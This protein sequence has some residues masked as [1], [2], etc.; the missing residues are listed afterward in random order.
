MAMKRKRGATTGSNYFVH[1]NKRRRRFGARRRRNGR[2]GSQFTSAQAGNSTSI[3]F[4]SRKLRP[5]AY[6]NALWKDTLFKTHY[7]SCIDRLSS[8]QMPADSRDSRIGYGPVHGD[9]AFWTAGGGA[10]AVDSTTPLPLFQDDITIRG[11]YGSLT[12]T[13]VDAN[14]AIRVKLYLLRSNPSPDFG[15]LPVDQSVVP[16]SAS[17][18]DP[19]LIPDLERFGRVVK[20]YDFILLP[21]QRPITLFERLRV[22]KV[23][24]NIFQVAGGNRMY[25]MYFCS[26]TSNAD[27]VNNTL[28]IQ[29]SHNLSF[30][31]DVVTPGISPLVPAQQLNINEL[32]SISSLI[33][34]G[35]PGS[36][37]T[38]GL[39][40]P[41]T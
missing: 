36:S 10:R 39:V 40:R 23:D 12:F 29:F 20:G 28:R 7:R 26:Q 19:S 13:N 11:G 24:Q 3:K 15:V 2:R 22:Q 5:R 6:R 27:S 41:S 9:L 21:G 17:T 4:R 1:G 35:R 14:D 16:L 33:T 34:S 37:I 30:S 8:V 38:P 32:P 18:V 31:G 25:W